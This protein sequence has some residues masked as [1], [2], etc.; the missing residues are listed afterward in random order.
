MP[1]VA[2]LGYALG[3]KLGELAFGGVPDA[4][5]NV[6]ARALEEMLATKQLNV[7]DFVPLPAAG[8]NGL[9][10]AVRISDDFRINIARAADELELVS[11]MPSGEKS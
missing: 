3:L 6:R 2:S 1:A 9:R 5:H 10:V 11:H 7:F 8:T 4:L